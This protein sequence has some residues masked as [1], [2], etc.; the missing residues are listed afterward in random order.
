MFNYLLKFRLKVYRKGTEI[1]EVE[2]IAF[3]IDYCLY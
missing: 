3:Y 2:R 1:A